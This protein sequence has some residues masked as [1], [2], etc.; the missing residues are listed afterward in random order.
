[1]PK[2][3]RTPITYDLFARVDGDTS[4]EKLGNG[5]VALLDNMVLNNPYGSASIRGAWRLENSNQTTNAVKRL[6][7]VKDKDNQEWYIA[8]QSDRLSR[9]LGGT[10]TDIKT[11]LTGD[12]NIQY[13]Q[14]PNGLVFTNGSDTPFLLSGSDFTVDDNVEISAPD[15]SSVTMQRITTDVGDL[16]PSC[17]YRWMLVYV[18]ET[19][20]RSEPS[21]PFCYVVS[22]STYDQQC[23]ATKR[24][25]LLQALPVSSD[26]RVTHKIL[27]RT[28][29]YDSTAFSGD[30]E[31]YTGK[32]YY[33]LATLQND[34][35]I[36]ADNVADEDL[37]FSDTVMFVRH[38]NVAE[39][40][41]KSN[42]RLFYGNYIL[43]K[44]HQWKPT[45]TVKPQAGDTTYPAGG[46]LTYTN[47]GST[48]NIGEITLSD[49]ITGLTP[50]EYYQYMYVYVDHNGLE[51]R[52]SYQTNV[53]LSG[54]SASKR[55][56]ISG[57]YDVGR[58]G[59]NNSLHQSPT[60]KSRRIYRT[61]GQATSFTP[62]SK[63]FFLVEEQTI[64]TGDIGTKLGYTYTDT[65][66]DSSLGSQ[67][68]E[69]TE[70]QF[71]SI[72]W[73]QAD[74]YSYLLVEN[75]RQVFAEDSDPITGIH[76]DGNGVLIWKENTIVKL[77]HTG[78]PQNWYLRK[79]SHDIGCDTPLSLVKVG[80]TYYFAYREKIYSMVS[81]QAPIDISY[82][83]YS[84]FSGYTILGA[85]GN[86]QW[87]IF[88]IT[89]TATGTLNYQMIYD[90][91]VKTW[92]RF[93]F[94][95]NDVTTTFIKK[96]DTIDPNNHNL[97]FMFVDKKTYRYDPTS[98]VDQ[99]SGSDTAINTKIGFPLFKIEGY[100]SKVRN[101]II[102]WTAT[103]TGSMYM[104]WTN[105]AGLTAQENVNPSST[106]LVRLNPPNNELSNH[107]YLEMWGLI[108]EIK[109]IQ[110]DLRPSKRKGQ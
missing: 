4:I 16:R 109:S 50:S 72:A 8:C 97:P 70:D 79:V 108:S 11:G 68:V 9:G 7:D 105:D 49:N 6:L 110:V 65:K 81:G 22:S 39:Y 91:I 88:T 44:I 23:S 96:Y 25:F 41:T 76:D 15:I 87:I 59:S 63:P 1:M 92:Y 73:S 13:T 69:D 42:N 43:P 17:T 26:S 12:G 107:W 40:V 52:P 34:E 99:F 2:E 74:R 90:K 5:T 28:E 102:D 104:R 21:N 51:G 78:A 46:S 36:F 35:T 84:D 31:L 93:T 61:L 83:K 53:F 20:E 58:V 95:A 82:G 10:W 38:P 71:S 19:G 89:D 32:I 75:V 18:T 80:D 47:G 27:Y 33:R 101:I 30:G 57:L 54:G 106:G 94:G 62:N 100:E 66:N 14:I 24:R 37:D 56:A 29:G 98:I 85:V 48:N 3:G 60:I 86:D 103:G 55:Q 67:Y 45:V 77:Y 64:D